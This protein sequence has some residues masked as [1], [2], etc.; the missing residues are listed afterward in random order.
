VPNP[1]D[2][3][4]RV[5]ARSL[6]LLLSRAEFAALELAQ[7][8]TQLTRWLLLALVCSIAVQLALLAASAALVLVLWE[9]FGP[10]TLVALALVYAG[11]GVG[12]FMRLRRQITE[13]PPLLSETLGELAKDRDAFFGEDASKSEGESE[14][15]TAARKNREI[16]RKAGLDTGREA[17]R[18]V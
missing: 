15:D 6:T 17:G 11:A 9:R 18:K 2:S 5:G 3:L 8:R 10:L 16:P 4:R 7:A 12:V 1:L 14:V 13:A